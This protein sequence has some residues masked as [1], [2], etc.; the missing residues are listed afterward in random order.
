MESK[1]I[2]GLMNRGIL[3]FLRIIEEMKMGMLESFDNEFGYE[4]E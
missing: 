2:K 1:G 3:F 4:L